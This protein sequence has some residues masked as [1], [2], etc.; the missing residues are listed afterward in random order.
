MIR[1]PGMILTEERARAYLDQGIW[2]NDTFIDVFE[3][4]VR[5]CGD[6]VHRDDD[7]RLSYREL[8]AECE[9]VAATLYELG[10]RKGDKVAIQLPTS[11]DYLAALFGIARIGAIAVLLQTDLAR[12]GVSF[13]LRK[14]GAKVMIV[15]D[16]YRGQPIGETAWSL[17][18]ELPDLHTVIIQGAQGPVPEG[19]LRFE[20]VRGAGRRLDPEAARENRPEVL[21]AFV[22]VFTSG[23]T[24]SPKG[25]V[26]LHANYLWAARAYAR[27][28]GLQPGEGTLDMAPICHQTGMLMGVAMPMVTGGRILLVERFAAGRVLRWIAE[29]KPSYLVGAPPHV[30]HLAQAPGLKEAET[31]SVRL[32]FYAGAPVPSSVL[33][34][35]QEDT[36]WTVGGMFG[37]TEGFVATATRPDDPVEVISSTVGYA[38]PGIEVKLVDEEGRPVAPGQP[39]EMWSRGPNFSAG[40]YDNP[41][42]AHRQWDADG[43]FH[44]GDLFRQDEAGRYIFMGRADDIIN[45]GGTKIDPKS[46]EDACAAHPAVQNVAVIGTPD[47]TLGQRTVACVVLKEG[48]QPFSLAE[49]RDFLGKSGLA[50]FQF[51]DRLVFLDALPMTHSGKIKKKELREWYEREGNRKAVE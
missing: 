22:M 47:P 50:K 9:S 39:G 3:R 40:Y 42:A 13:S 48:A 14:S 8:W 24:G 18:E 37:W 34:Q 43:W 25:V 23:T 46:V 44:S 11:L 21:D 29:E 16:N 2:Q 38:I 45:R 49:L 33:K 17:R 31:S 36:G 10:I 27:W 19:A 26:Q 5:E 1:F 35:L 51:P 15:A 4:N 7:R 6:L 30:I 28:Y 20:E 12:Q 32:F 41:E